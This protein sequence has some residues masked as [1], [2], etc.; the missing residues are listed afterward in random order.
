MID[1]RLAWPKLAGKKPVGFF[2]TGPFFPLYKMEPEMPNEETEET[3]NTMH[4]GPQPNLK[5][6]E[7]VLLLLIK[8]MEESLKALDGMLSL[9]ERE[10]GEAGKKPQVAFPPGTNRKRAK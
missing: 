1:S 6:F 9:H 5:E 10:K 8:Q 4:E 3:L 2:P 7:S